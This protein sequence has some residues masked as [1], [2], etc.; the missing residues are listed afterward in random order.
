MH[1]SFHSM[2]VSFQ[3]KVVSFYKMVKLFYKKLSNSLIS[4]KL[5]IPNL[6]VLVKAK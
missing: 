1:V 6:E 3:V 5:I 4:Y 2:L